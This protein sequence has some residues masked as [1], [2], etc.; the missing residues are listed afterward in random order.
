MNYKKTYI[1][2]LITIIWSWTFWVIGLNYLTDGINQESIRKFLIFFLLAYM[3][4][5]LAEL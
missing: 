2:L 4:Q 1:F 5:Q 3:D